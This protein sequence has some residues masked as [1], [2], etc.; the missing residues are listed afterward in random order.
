MKSA[1]ARDK[2]EH[3]LRISLDSPS[4]SPQKRYFIDLKSTQQVS[5]TPKSISIDFKTSQLSSLKPPIG[6]SRRLSMATT[7]RGTSE[8]A[9]KFGL[10]T[11]KSLNSNSE[12]NSEVVSSHNFNFPRAKWEDI[13]TPISPEEVISLFSESIP[14]W[15]QQELEKYSEVYYIGKNFKPKEPNFDDE[16]GDYKLLIKDHIAFRYEVIALIGKGSFGQVLEV[17]DHKSKKSVAIKLVKNK[18][19]FHQQAKIEVEILKYIKEF[20]TQ[21]SSNI[22]EILDTF[23]FRNHIVSLT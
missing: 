13:T 1:T 8:S 21:K 16:E 9:L 14:H 18:P 11:M 4:R 22:I 3:R 5:N 12:K 19:K 10:R 23:T 7:P 17:F 20:D 15:E 2:L 6:S